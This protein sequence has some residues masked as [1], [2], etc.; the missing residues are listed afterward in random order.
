MWW[1]SFIAVIRRRHRAFHDT[2][3]IGYG[4]AGQK[5]IEQAVI[6]AVAFHVQDQLSAVIVANWHQEVLDSI[7]SWVSG[8]V[9]T[10]RPRR[11]LEGAH[12]GLLGNLDLAEQ[13][14]D[15]WSA[16]LNDWFASAAWQTT[17]VGGNLTL[18]CHL[19]SPGGGHAYVS[20]HGTG[21][22][23]ARLR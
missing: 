2:V 8:K 6:L 5:L 22:S 23:Y 19:L 7:V 10:L 16:Q 3:L 12:D 15:E 18:V 17:H 13:T 21:E 14:Q 1:K 11:M 4:S 9:P 20:Q